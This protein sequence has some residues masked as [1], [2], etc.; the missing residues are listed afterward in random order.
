M[1]AVREGISK[2]DDFLPHRIMEEPIKNGR[3]EGV[4]IGK[5]NME[6]MLKEYYNLRGWDENG[7]PKNEKF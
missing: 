1:L 2:K 6:I 7:I 4:K 3:A 5:D